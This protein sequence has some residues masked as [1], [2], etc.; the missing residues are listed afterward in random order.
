[1]IPLNL[2]L[3]PLAEAASELVPGEISEVEVLPDAGAVVLIRSYSEGGELDWSTYS[4]EEL[5]GLVQQV[6]YEDT[7][8]TLVDSLRNV[9]PVVINL[10]VAAEES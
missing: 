2:W 6:I 1:M 9:V 5:Q 8:N 4:E 7:Y 10:Q 3:A